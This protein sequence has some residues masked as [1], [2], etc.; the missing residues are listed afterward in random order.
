[1]KEK[2]LIAF[3]LYDTCFTFTVPQERLSYKQIFSDLGI[4]MDKRI[5]LRNVLLTS[6]KTMEDVLSTLIPS[7]QIDRFID[8]YYANLRKEVQSVQLFPETQPTLSVLREK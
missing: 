2:K 7:A 8:T 6:H 4:P 1:M 5:E 3:D